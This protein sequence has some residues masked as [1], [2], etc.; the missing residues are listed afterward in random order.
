MALF[1]MRLVGNCICSRLRAIEWDLDNLSQKP[2]RQ[3]LN[4][5]R[6]GKTLS[7]KRRVVVII[8]RENVCTTLSAQFRQGYFPVAFA[9]R[10]GKLRLGGEFGAGKLLRGKT[11]ALISREYTAASQ[12]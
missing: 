6:S 7:R 4:G 3:I 8:S 11:C 5:Y 2:V 12:T 1:P 9:L 10:L